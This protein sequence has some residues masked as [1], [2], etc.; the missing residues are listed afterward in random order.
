MVHTPAYVF[1][2]A[3]KHGLK[4]HVPITFRADWLANLYVNTM[5]CIHYSHDKYNYESLQ[6][7]LHDTDVHR[8]MAFGVAGLS[9]VADSLSAIRYAKV[10]PIRNEQGIAIDFTSE[11]EFP[12]FGN[13]NPEYVT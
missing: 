4:Q 12:K 1:V 10:T 11:G 5:N 2:H 3:T 8:F 7:A 9:V 13:D 6:M